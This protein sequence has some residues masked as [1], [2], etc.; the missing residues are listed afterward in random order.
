MK[1]QRTKLVIGMLALVTLIGSTVIAADPN[2]P[3]SKPGYDKTKDVDAK[4]PQGADVLFDGTQESVQA[5]WEMWPK[6]DMAITWSLVD[7]LN[8][9]DKVL[10]T[11]GGK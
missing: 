8:G 2:A 1:L 6:P 9:S 4:A 3:E 11:N 10:M 7:S 5:N